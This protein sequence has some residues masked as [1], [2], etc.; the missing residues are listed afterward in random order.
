MWAVGWRCHFIDCVARK[1]VSP[2]GDVLRMCWESIVE[3]QLSQVHQRQKECGDLDLDLARTQSDV[4]ARGRVE[5]ALS[6]R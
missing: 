1:S 2:A 5:C 3:I 4:A 6:W